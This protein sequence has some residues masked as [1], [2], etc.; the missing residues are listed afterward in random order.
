MSSVND[1]LIKRYQNDKVIIKTYYS[2]SKG[3]NVDRVVNPLRI[4]N[5]QLMAP[6]D[7]QSRY[8]ACAGYSACTLIESLYWKMT[9]KLIQLDSKQVYAKA[10]E[11]D[12]ERDMEGTYL[13][14]S[15]QA[16]LSLCDF[17]FLKTARI[18]IFSNGKDLDTIEKTKFLI[19]KYGFLQAGFQIDESWHSVN[20]KNYVIS[21]GGRSLGGHAVNLVGYDSSGVYIQ[22]QWGSMWGAKGFAVMPWDLYLYELMYGTYISGIR[23]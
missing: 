5:R 3:I 16:A 2:D 8:P 19:H 7:N 14:T 18:E 12:G 13:E 23:Y 6:T 20:G 21:R 10:K 15:L 9:G 17:D 11:L 1:E 4:D 22:N